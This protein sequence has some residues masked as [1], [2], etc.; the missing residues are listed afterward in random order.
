MQWAL[1]T[2]IQGVIAEINKMAGSGF[3]L[4]IQFTIKLFALIV[5]SLVLIARNFL[6]CF[7]ENGKH[8]KGGPYINLYY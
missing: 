5:D 4:Q 3:S 2:R 1:G 8:L 7:L 6:A